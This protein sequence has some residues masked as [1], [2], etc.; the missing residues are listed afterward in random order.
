MITG[1]HEVKSKAAALALL[2]TLVGVNTTVGTGQARPA[3]RPTAP[4]VKHVLLLSLDGMHA[5]DLANYVKARPKSSLA[6]LSQHG[7]TYTNALALYHPTRG[8]GCLP[9]S[10]EVL[11]FPRA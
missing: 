5:L 2:L 10:P 4:R 8:Q 7:I 1:S 6:Q 11:L 9:W 3:M